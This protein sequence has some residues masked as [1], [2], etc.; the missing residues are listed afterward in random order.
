[1]K[2]YV[3]NSAIGLIVALGGTPAQ[4]HA[5]LKTASPRVGSNVSPAPTEVHIWFTEEIDPGGTVIKVYDSSGV[6]VDRG[7]SH[8]DQ[9]QNNLESVTL[10][11]LKDGKYTVQWQATCM[12]GHLTS[13]HYSFT[14]QN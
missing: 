1:M 10:P 5:F 9:S 3:V 6:E 14:V 2:K 4:A 13:G 7:D 11:V 12:A 8:P